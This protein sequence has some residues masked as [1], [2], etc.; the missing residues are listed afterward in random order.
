MIMLKLIDMD[1]ITRI[2]LFVTQQQELLMCV[3][4]DLEAL[5][6]Y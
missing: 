4:L 5:T 6:N 3:I 2:I 1:S